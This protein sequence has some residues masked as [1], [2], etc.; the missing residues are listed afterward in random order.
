MVRWPSRCLPAQRRD[1]Y[2]R[3]SFRPLDRRRKTANT[4]ALDGVIVVRSL[5]VPNIIALPPC[6]GI[7]GIVRSAELAN[8]FGRNDA[9]H[10]LNAS[11]P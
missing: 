3:R 11:S 8:F 2:G 10:V 9:A 5:T 1:N 4:T 7:Q 6:V